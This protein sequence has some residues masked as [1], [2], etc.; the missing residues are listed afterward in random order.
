M[1]TVEGVGDDEPQHGVAEELE[2]L[3]GGLRVV[4][5]GPRPVHEGAQQQ[6]RLDLEAEPGLELRG[7]RDQLEQARPG[8]GAALPGGGGAQRSLTLRPLYSR[9]RGVPWESVTTRA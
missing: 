9:Y 5:V 4:L 6:A 7:A 2:A 1:A 3:V 8:G